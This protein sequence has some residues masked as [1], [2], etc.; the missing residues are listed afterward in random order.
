MNYKFMRAI[1]MFGALAL[2][3]IAGSSLYAQS[4]AH[5]D[6]AETVTT[7]RGLG[8]ESAEAVG[9]ASVYG[10]SET[11]RYI[12]Q[13]SDPAVPSYTGGIA[14]LEATSPQVTGERRLDA[15]SPAVQAYVSYLH[16]KQDEFIAAM[17]LNLGRSVEVVFR[18]DGAM[19]GLAVVVSHEEAVALSQLPGVKA[20]FGDT[21]QEIETDIGP[22]FLGAPSIWGSDFDNHQFS[23]QLTGDQ[24]NPPVITNATGAGAFTY[25]LATRELSWEISHDINMGDVTGAHIHVGAVGV[26][27]PVVIPLD[28]TQNPMVGSATLTLAQQS[29]LMNHLYYVNVHTTAHPGGEI[30]GQMYISDVRGEGVIA[31]IIDTG[32]NFQHPSFAATD[33]LG[34]TH[35]NPYGAGNYNGWC[36]ANPGFCTDKLIGAY[37]LNPLGGNPADDHGHGSHTGST[38]AGNYHEAVFVVG[39]ETYTRTVAGVAPRAN[40]VAYKVCTPGCPQTAS[41]QAV[42]HAIMDDMVDVLNYS[43]SGVD[44]PW[45]DSVDLAFLEAFNAGIYIAA[46]AGNAGPGPSTAAK[47][48][49]WNA[50]TAAS[51]INRIIAHTLDV[52]GPTT[53]PELQDVAA[54]P[55]ENTTLVADINGEL[56]FNA[57]N[58]RGCNPGH[59]AN[60]FSGAIALVERGDCTFAEK[61]NN[62]AAAG[63]TEV[64]VYNHFGGPP[65]VMGGLLGNPTPAVMID[66]GSGI[67]LRA[68]VI[69]NPGATVRINTATSLVF[70]DDWENVVAGFSSRGPSQFEMLLPTFIAPGVNTLAAGA[71]GSDHYYFSQGTSMSSPH[72]A[73]AG[74]LLMAL[75]PTW[76][77]AQVRSA[78]AMT[79][80][81]SGLV[82]ENGVTPADPFDVGSGLLDLDAAGRIGLVMDETYA[83]FVAANPGAGGD[84]KTLNLPA[85]LNYNCTGECS[86]TRTVTSVAQDTVTYNA[87]ANAPAGMVITVDPPSFTID[88]GET[89]ELVI[90]V[91]VAGSPVGSFAFADIRL[92]PLATM[93]NSYGDFVELGESYGHSGTWTQ[94]THAISAYEGQDVCLGFVYQGFDG[95]D[96]FVDDVSVV[97]DAGTDLFE[98]FTDATFP[99]A[100]WTQYNIDGGGSQWARSLTNY[101]A[102]ASALHAYSTAG[103]QDGWL[104]SPQFTVGDN[105]DF[106]YYDRMGFVTWYTYSGV[107]ISAGNCDPTWVPPTDVASVHMPVAVIPA[108]AVPVITVDPDEMSA[109]QAPDEV[110]SQILTI[111]NAG[112]VDLDWEIAEAPAAMQLGLTIDGDPTTL[113]SPFSLILDG[114]AADT[115][116]GVGGIQFVWLN[117]FTPQ[118]YNFPIT[119]DEVQV[120]FGS[121][122]GAG[123]ISVGQLVD[124]YLYEDADGNPA[125]GATHRASLNNQAVQAVNGTTWS[126]YPVAP[127]IT[128]DGPGDIIIAVVNR[129]AGVTAGTFPASIDRLTPNQQRSWIGWN[130]GGDPPPGD[131]PDFSTFGTFN[132]IGNLN[133]ALGGNWLVRGFGTGNVPC[134]NPA[135]VSWLDVNPDMGTTGP[136]STTDVTVTFDSTGLASGEYNAFLCVESNDPATPLVEVPVTLEVLAQAMIEVDPESI[137]S[138]QTPDVATV[139]TLDISNTGLADLIWNIEEAAPVAVTGPI[140]AAVRDLPVGSDRGTPS[141]MGAPAPA[142]ILPTT[143]NQLSSSWSESFDDITLLPGMGWAMI[144]NSQ[145]LGISGWFQ[146]NPAVF[147][148]HSGATNSYIGAN[149]NNTTGN[150]TISNWLLTPETPLNNGDEFTFWT[151]RTTSV[152]EDRLQVRLSTNGGSTDV[153]ATATSVGDFTDLLLDINPTYA[154]G[155][156]PQVWTEYTITISGLGGP[157]NGRLAFRYFVES[158]GPDGANSDYIGID[159]VSYTSSVVPPSVLYDNGPFVTSFGDGPGG[160]DVSLLQ[161]QSLGLTTLGAAVNFSGGGPH[162]RIADE[163]TVTTPGGWTV[164]NLVFYGYQ[165]GSSTTSSFTGVNYR[166]WDGPPNDPD[167][168]VVFGD[169]TTNRFEATGWTGAYR[170]AQT[171][172]GN[173]DRPIMYIVGEGGVHLMPGT[174]WLDWQLAGTIASGPWQMPITII[175]QTTTGNAVRLV[176]AGWEPFLDGG[177]GNPA[178]GAPFQLWGGTVCDNPSDVSWISVDPDSGMTEPGETSQV[179]VTLDSTGVAVG[180]YTAYLCVNSN[181]LENPV[182]VVPVTLTV[183]PA[184]VYGVTLSPAAAAMS[185]APG[186]VVTYT[187]TIT[188]TGDTTDSFT[189][190]ASDNDWFVGLPLMVTLDM[191]ESTQVYV[192]VEIPVGAAHGASDMA[193]ITATSAGDMNVSAASELT[194]TAV[195]PAPTMWYLYLPVV[196]NN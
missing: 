96:W 186:D 19:N 56:R 194:T 85:F 15:K 43:I 45:N 138:T 83:N 41:V 153:G 112:G 66:N 128:F 46:S 132:I 126:V 158:G 150:N 188:N 168:N 127:A 52:T 27:G 105:A 20:V 51:T 145:P 173:T 160:S 195:V 75:N 48:G 58:P 161:N 129:T 162:F 42:N 187:L 136:G 86:W 159:T 151:R 60:F 184:P 177:A 38:T 120:M 179:E 35:T 69:A 134:D 93:V 170:Y 12:I 87:V 113:S 141:V 89:Q 130:A 40:V 152:Y 21:E 114:G 7:V 34:Y 140:P 165:T 79:A 13:L 98:D 178:Q 123:G 193:T 103:V 33:G 74:A 124:I 25:N 116:I 111:G 149:F 135:D 146:G 8:L 166:I 110:T 44:N 90:T 67:A 180:E 31:G 148:A 9:G 39:S 137:A 81:P 147:S 91:D 28:H 191:G 80:N 157:T 37:G 118:T 71:F 167:S 23:A 106:T 11:G 53:P 108:L 76:S 97:S 4:E 171:A 78:L 54:V 64:V 49:P 115:A 119:I 131:P 172:I 102:P 77:P 133:P 192:T 164:D 144:N 61:V 32:V 36:A 14:G 84:P 155:G 175:G 82:K 181:D 26:N 122:V 183:V 196:F 125:N 70:N 6:E 143:A 95:H 94:R 5:T 182:V 109:A 50:S 63:A 10:V 88:P 73:G 154:P 142:S 156:Y 17:G 65:S 100:G 99:P 190:S 92:V 117:R 104:V 174:Y 169:T 57:A 24:E 121:N 185:G 101:S 72:A 163:F 22:W 1:F 2:F 189:F 107:W 59:P 29:D 16:Q 18:Y 3:V 30:R 176:S 47:S 68:Y 62:A 55:G 139:H